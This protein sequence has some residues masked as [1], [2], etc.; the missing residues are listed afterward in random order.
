[1]YDNWTYLLSLSETGPYTL[2]EAIVW[3]VTMRRPVTDIELVDRAL[4][5][6][7]RKRGWPEA[8]G[9][10]SAPAQQ[11]LGLWLLPLPVHYLDDPQGG[12]P[13]K[14]QAGS[15]Q[16]AIKPL[17]A[18]ANDLVDLAGEER[19]AELF[20]AYENHLEACAEVCD[21]AGTTHVLS[22]ITDVAEAAD[23]LDR[24]RGL[25]WTIEDIEAQG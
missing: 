18:A 16:V 11:E 3:D 13:F 19:S 2:E 10:W 17:I 7:A 9:W 21:V 6:L 1:V 5:R 24:P 4:G 23:L 20:E 14:V 15:S 22:R 25:R 8:I 12:P